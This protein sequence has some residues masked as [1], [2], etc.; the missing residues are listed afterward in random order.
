VGFSLVVPDVVVAFYYLPVSALRVLYYSLCWTVL[1][2][3]FLWSLGFPIVVI[4]IHNYKCGEVPNPLGVSLEA[5]CLSPNPL[6][7]RLGLLSSRL[8]LR[9]A[10][11]V[12]PYLLCK[13]SNVI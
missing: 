8:T 3:T 7:P 2:E 13:L 5:Q 9:E 10:K 4:L 6:S 1:V 11:G 12:R